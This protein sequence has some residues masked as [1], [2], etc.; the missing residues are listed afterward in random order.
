MKKIIINTA[1]AVLGAFASSAV[2]AQAY[3]N[4]PITLVVPQAAG[5]TNDIVGRLIAPAYGEAIGTQLLLKISRV[6]AA[7]LVLKQ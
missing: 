2:F 3:P 1:F 7:I 5:G 4:K 6:L